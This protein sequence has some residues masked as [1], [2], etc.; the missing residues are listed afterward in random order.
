MH[1]SMIATK[2][3]FLF[4]HQN[5]VAAAISEALSVCLDTTQCR[6]VCLSVIWVDQP[7]NTL[8]GLGGAHLE[9]LHCAICH[10]FPTKAQIFLGAAKFTK[11]QTIAFTPPT[12]FM[13]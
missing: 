9:A 11:T 1:E 13:Q 3:S 2:G 12:A 8:T 4:L 6:N 10:L 5:E 7:F